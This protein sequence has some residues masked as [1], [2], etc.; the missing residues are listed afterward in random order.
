VKLPPIVNAAW[1][2]TLGNDQLVQAEAKLHAEFSALEAKEKRRAGARYTML[3]GPEPLVNAWLR[4]LMVN[5]AALERGVVR[6]PR[7][8]S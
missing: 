3:R 4:W 6:K 8:R 2:A 1:I 5:N 7:P